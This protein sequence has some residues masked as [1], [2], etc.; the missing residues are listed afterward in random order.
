[1]SQFLSTEID[2]F[3]LTTKKVKSGCI[4]WQGSK[5]VRYY[6]RSYINGRQATASR[7]SYTMFVGPIPE[8][9]HILHSCDNPPCV[10]P[11][12]LRPGTSKENMQEREQKGR[13]KAAKGSGHGMSKLTEDDIREIRKTFRS[14]SV[15]FGARGLAKKFKV[16]PSMVYLIISNKNW[17]HVK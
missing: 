6:G 9:L 4:E 15:E 8:G 17:R 12:H 11:A 16:D 14:G 2:E 3:V 10:N 5:F 7:V 1:M 13:R